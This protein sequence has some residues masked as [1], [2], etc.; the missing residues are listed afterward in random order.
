MSSFCVKTYI[1]QK[2]SGEVIAVKL[3][4]LDAHQIAKEHAP[5]KVLFAAADKT[6]DLNVSEHFVDQSVQLTAHPIANKL[7]RIARDSRAMQPR[8]QTNGTL[9]DDHG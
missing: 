6:L 1:V 7:V 3:K 5:A 4:F 2:S 8:R 9:R